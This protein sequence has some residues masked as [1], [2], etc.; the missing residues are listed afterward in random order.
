MNDLES[1]L[2]QILQAASPEVSDS[3]IIEGRG[4][5]SNSP[6]IGGWGANDP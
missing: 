4:A 6:I 1:V 3:P 2:N 5:T